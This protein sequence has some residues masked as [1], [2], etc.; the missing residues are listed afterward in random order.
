M[1]PF[2]LFRLSSGPALAPIEGDLVTTTIA[3]F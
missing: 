2:L 1:I 3:Y